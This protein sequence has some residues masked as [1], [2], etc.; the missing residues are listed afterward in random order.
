MGP[1]K[2]QGISQTTKLVNFH[3]LFSLTNLRKQLFNRAVTPV[4]FQVTTTKTTVKSRAVF[5][6]FFIK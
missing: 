6:H 4:E 3:L 2:G 5:A 1:V